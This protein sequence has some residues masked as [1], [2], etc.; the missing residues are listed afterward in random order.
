MTTKCLFGVLIKIS[1][2]DIDKYQEIPVRQNINAE[3][4]FGGSTRVSRI[5]VSIIEVKN[6]KRRDVD[7]MNIYG[8]RY[9]QINCST[10]RNHDDDLH[11]HLDNVTNVNVQET[12]GLYDI[13]REP[14]DSSR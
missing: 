2:Y 13:I 10:E 8:I 5:E 4:E 9:I 12:N 3:S 11:H 6:P 14:Y 7:W 1:R